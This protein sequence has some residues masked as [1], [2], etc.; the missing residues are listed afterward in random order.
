MGL[1][2]AVYRVIRWVVKVL[3]PRTE[4]FGTEHLPEGACIVV[5]NHAQMNGPIASELYF[6]GKR[7]IWCAGQ[8]M[9]LREVPAYA[10]EDFWSD[11][12]RW[13]RWFYRLLAYCIAPL[14]VCIFNSAH[15]IPVYRDSRSLTTFRRSVQALE[16][17]TRVIIFPER[18]EPHNRIVCEFQERFVDTARLYCR[19]TGGPVSFVP[20]Y[21]APR[22]KAMYL[23]EPIPF[24][25]AAPIEDER[26]RICEALMASI[27]ELAEALPRH[28][29]VPYQNVPK[30]QY[31]VNLPPRGEP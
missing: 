5:G 23:G 27:T 10:F 16:E 3:Y 18:A 29:V 19:R 25:P 8:M 7:A 13:C 14:S 30:K 6:P 4:V 1:R 26:R 20:M 9:E 22:L 2:R 21:V 31:P 24:D 28:T 11:K 15:T 12:P 17:G